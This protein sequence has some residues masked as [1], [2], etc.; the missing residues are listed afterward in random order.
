MVESEAQEREVKG[1]AASQ[2]SVGMVV[3]GDFYLQF[4]GVAAVLN[5]SGDRYRNVRWRTLADPRVRELGVEQR[6]WVVTDRT[7]CEVC[8]PMMISHDCRHAAVIVDLVPIGAPPAARAAP[9]VPK[10]PA[11]VC[12]GG[13]EAQGPGRQVASDGGL[14]GGGAAIGR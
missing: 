3:A 7:L 2:G 14:A 6:D 4:D 5:E 8:V 12:I 11:T 10:I 9:T 1:S 13:S